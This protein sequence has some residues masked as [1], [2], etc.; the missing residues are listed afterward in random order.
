VA[1]CVGGW[2]SGQRG[3]LDRWSASELAGGVV[4]R[5]AVFVGDQRRSGQRSVTLI[6]GWS[7]RRATVSLGDEFIIA[8]QAVKRGR[9]TRRVISVVERVDRENGQLSG[10]HRSRLQ[11][12]HSRW[13]L[14]QTDL[15]SRFPCHDYNCWQNDAQL[16][17][18]IYCRLRK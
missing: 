9:R 1:T 17:I 15:T 5:A 7:A 14:T 12:D 11:D 2:A 10:L 8:V 6:T 4:P 13:P 16:I 3:P 18:I